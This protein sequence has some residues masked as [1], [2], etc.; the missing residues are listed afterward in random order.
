MVLH[1][2]SSGSAVSRLDLLDKGAIV[3]AFE[4]FGTV[5]LEDSEAARQL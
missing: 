5:E 2:H 1:Q 3:C 4:Q